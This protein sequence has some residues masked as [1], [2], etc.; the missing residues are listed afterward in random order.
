MKKLLLLLFLF[1][2]LATPKKVYAGATFDISADAKYFVSE[3]G[4]TTIDQ[5]IVIVNNTEFIYTPSYKIVTGLK[6]IS[7]VSVYNSNGALPFDLKKVDQGNEINISF[8][9]KI[10]GKGRINSFTIS[11]QTS[12]VAKKQGSIWEVDI[13]GLSN[14]EEYSSYNIS[15]SVPSSFGDVSI[16]KPPKSKP[17]NAIEFNRDEI[18][19]SGIF[20]LFGDKQIYKLNLTYHISNPNLFPIKTEIAIPPDTQYQDVYVNSLSPKPLDV[21]KDSDENWLAV[22][23]L[24]PK[25]QQLITADVLV[26]VYPAP[27]NNNKENL[28]SYL[29]TTD[30]KYW[31]S[32]DPQIQSIAKNLHSA[33]DVYKFVVSNLSYN[34][35]KVLD[36]NT[37]LGAKDALKNPKNA[38]CLEFT[39]LFIALARASGIPAREVEGYA[40]TQNS[41]LRPLS[42]VKDVLHAWPEYYDFDK[43]QWLMV[44]PTWGNTTSG[45]DYFYTFDFDHI[46][47]V[48]KGKDSNYPVPAGGYK[49]NSDS[50]DIAVKFADKI[51]AI[52]INKFDVAVDIPSDYLSGFPISG[53]VTIQNLGPRPIEGKELLI[54]STF[55]GFIEQSSTVKL[56][57]YASKI[58]EVG[59]NRTPFLTNNTYAVTISFDGNT[60]RKNVKVS[61]FPPFGWIIVI[62]GTSIGSVIFIVL[63]FKAGSIFIQ[64]FKKRDNLHR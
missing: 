20:V 45:L 46:A 5:N 32:K 13:P 9:E 39:D 43:K 22:Y 61:I 42:L 2:L 50:K 11:F 44:D 38:V 12:E 36:A 56:L 37:R 23:S 29:Y 35:N 48:I 58:Y 19:K 62:G 28:S 64:K 15:L 24:G 34:Y 10:I 55:P 25:T 33:Y 18:G 21:Y 6:D 47:F 54:G 30:A 31:E 16:I 26:S 3:S 1:F 4:T 8:L 51:E 7:S 60:Y 40:Y 52:P 17:G 49:F 63:A 41:K 53:R 59:F 27:K 14:P 57:P